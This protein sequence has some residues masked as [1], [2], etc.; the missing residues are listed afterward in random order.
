MC[1]EGTV[2]T[3]GLAGGF[4]YFLAD[5]RADFVRTGWMQRFFAQA[6]TLKWE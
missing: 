5:G 4:D 2:H 6:E 1:L 3:T